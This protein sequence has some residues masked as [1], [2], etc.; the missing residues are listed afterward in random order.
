MK[1]FLVFCGFCSLGFGWTHVGNN[2]RGWNAKPVTF[3]V[4]SANCPISESELYGIIDSA[5][6]TWNG[7]TDSSLV[8]Q[9]A[10]SNVNITVTDFLAGN[11]TQLPVILCDPN[12]ATQVGSS[13]SDVIPAATFKTAADSNGHLT[14]SG[15]LLNAQ[16]GAGANIASL[17]NGQTELT[18]AHEM[19]HALGLG[20][21]SQS[22]SLMYYSLGSKVQPLLTEDDIDGIV[23]IYP[24]NEFA[25][26]VMGCSSV[27]S[28]RGERGYETVN[29]FLCLTIFLLSFGWGRYASSRSTPIPKN[30]TRTTSLI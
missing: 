30:Q 1:L 12:F 17:S 6:S 22:E 15:V 16:S 9:K 11:L 28:L 3:Y 27:H 13:G 25:G 18:L 20:H 14:Y 24:R 5:I 21:S 29:L 26:G 4:D 10:K 7:V 19:G 8:V 23:H 2:I